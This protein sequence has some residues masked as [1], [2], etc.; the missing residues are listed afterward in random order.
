MC[1]PRP[2]MP[3]SW[4][5]GLPATVPTQATLIDRQHLAQVSWKVGVDA[6]SEAHVVGDQLRRHRE[7]DRSKTTVRLR[8]RQVVVHIGPQGWMLG[9]EGDGPPATGRDL[10]DVVDHH[11]LVAGGGDEQHRVPVVHGRERAV[12]EFAGKDAL[13]V[14]IGDLFELEGALQGN[15]VRQAIAQVVQDTIN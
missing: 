1:K 2:T 14:G 10:V 15:G 3:P 8:D 6:A 9:G 4:C 13:A 12:L 11:H 5:M 7:Q